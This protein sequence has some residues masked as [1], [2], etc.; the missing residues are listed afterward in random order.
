M[1]FITAFDGKHKR[2]AGSSDSR[3]QYFEVTE[4]HIRQLW[5][6]LGLDDVFFLKYS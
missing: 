3:I 5:I 6:L 4:K 1:I 2:K